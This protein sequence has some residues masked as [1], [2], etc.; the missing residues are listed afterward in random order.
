MKQNRNRIRKIVA[1]I[2]NE[3]TSAAVDN[4]ISS[5]E[6]DLERLSTAEL[7]LL[8]M[9]V[10]QLIAQLGGSPVNE[11]NR[12]VLKAVKGLILEMRDDGTISDDE[13]EAQI[14]LM[15]HVEV[16]IDDLIGY[17]KEQSYAIGG[18]YRGPG[19]KAEALRLLAEKIHGAR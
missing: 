11:S 14:D 15:M 13:E 8:S 17:I 18:P 10:D 5:I 9:K 2:L 4:V 19:I 12:R 3:E 7:S 1:R 6:P 16:Q